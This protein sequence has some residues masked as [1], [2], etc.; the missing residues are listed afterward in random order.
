MLTAESRPLSHVSVYTSNLRPD[1][2]FVQQRLRSRLRHALAPNSSVNTTPTRA[3]ITLASRPLSCTHHDYAP[4]RPQSAPRDCAFLVLH[5][6]A[7]PLAPS[8]PNFATCSATARAFLCHCLRLPLLIS[9]VPWT[10]SKHTSQSVP[11]SAIQRSSTCSLV[12]PSPKT[13]KP[14][15]PFFMLPR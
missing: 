2:F 4:S 7:L 11:A 14:P 13:L 12:Q 10:L 6:R 1:F 15:T 3:P 9:V 8:P 5:Q